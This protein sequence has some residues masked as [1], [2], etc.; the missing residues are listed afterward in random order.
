M[1]TENGMTDMQEADLQNTR[2]GVWPLFF[3]GAGLAVVAYLC[4]G[5]I[6]NWKDVKKGLAEGYKTWA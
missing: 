4:K 2:G 6:D 1:K 3:A 5:T